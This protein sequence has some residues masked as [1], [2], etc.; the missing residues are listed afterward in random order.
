[1]KSKFLIKIKRLISWKYFS[2]F[3][4]IFKWSW[5][6]INDAR[7]YSPWDPYKYIN[8]KNTA[9]HN[10]LWTSIF[11]QEKDIT[12][13]VFFDINYNWKSWNE[14]KNYEKVMEF[15][16]DMIVYCKKNWIRIKVFY[17]QNSWLDR[18]SSIHSIDI[19]KHIERAYHF[20]DTLYKLVKHTPK[21]YKSWLENFI[22]IAKENKKRRAIVIFSD[23]LE[24]SNK[25][26]NVLEYFEKE[27]FLALIKIPVN[28][29]QGQNYNKFLLDTHHPLDV[30]NLQ[31]IEL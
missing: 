11:Q 20:I 21:Q 14:I 29:S 22:K 12:L 24:V 16:A 7:V 26:K 30:E 2:S 15:W 27:H 18:K 17:T 28:K 1:M 4:S 6:E 25:D 13:D 3:E 19:D 8:R 23:F 5:M 9:K 10:E 31:T